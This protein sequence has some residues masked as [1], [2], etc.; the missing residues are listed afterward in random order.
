MAPL[1]VD[2]INMARIRVMGGPG[3][4]LVAVC[5]LVAIYIPFIGLSLAAGSLFS[6]VVASIIIRRRRKSGP[7]PSS[8]RALGAGTVLKLQVSRSD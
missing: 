8:S 6:L 7:V 2:A 4:G 1:T 3:L 5:A